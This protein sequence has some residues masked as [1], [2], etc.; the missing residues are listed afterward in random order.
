MIIY[1]HVTDLIRQGGALQ[2]G[3]SFSHCVALLFLPG[4]GSGCF[5]VVI[6]GIRDMRKESHPGIVEK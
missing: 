2:E 1:S 5:A 4:F 6:T 3:F